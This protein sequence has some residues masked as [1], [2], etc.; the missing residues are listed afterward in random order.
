[1]KTDNLQNIKF[2]VNAFEK[3]KSF[4]IAVHQNPDGDTLGAALCTASILKR[5]GK[6]VYVFSTDKVPDNLKFMP[7]INQVKEGKLPSD[8]NFDVCLFFE[9]SSLK[10]AGDVKALAKKAKKIINIDHH[11]THSH[12]GHINYVDKNA[13]S[14]SE[15]VFEIFRKMKVKLD[16]KQ[17][18]CLYIGIVTDTGRFYYHSTTAKAVHIA[19]ELIKLGVDPYKINDI[20]YGTKAMAALKLLAIALQSLK[21]IRKKLAVMHLTGKDFKSAKAL[22]EHTEDIA[23]YGLMPPGVE[24]SVL[25]RELKNR[26]AVNLRSKNHCDVSKVAKLFGGGGHKNAAGFKTKLSAKQTEKKLLNIIK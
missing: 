21:I 23:N 15:M 22:A 14:T 4:F 1:M 20:I 19:A 11:K 13:S 18:E 2:I 9:C 26:T 24:V 10:R 6:K 25:I 5:Q 16:K 7:L 8:K 12:Y 3:Y 17:A